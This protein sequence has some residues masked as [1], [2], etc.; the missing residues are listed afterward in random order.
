MGLLRSE[1]LFLDRDAPP[2]EEAQFAAYKAV[3]QGMEG[4]P[5]IVRTLDIG[6]DKQ[7]ACL[8]LPNEENP[9]LG[10]RGVRVCLDRPELFKTQLRA[11][12]RASAF[13]RLAVMFPMIASVWELQECKKLCWQV[14]EELTREG[15][16]FCAGL[17]IGVMIETPAAVLLAPELAGLVDFFSVGTNDL[18]QYLLACDRQSAHLGRYY[19][20]HHPAV[21]RALKM[22]AEAAHAKGRWVGICGELGADLE[23]LPFFLELGV[24]ELSVSPASVLPVRRAWRA[25]NKAPRNG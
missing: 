16:S 13:G 14:M 4:K 6:S 2:D 12:F 10:L 15:R 8:P 9:A 5:V 25:L 24:D 23:L 17:E 11:I 7:T 18:T 1:F 19:D 21:L 3:A 22:V 20:P